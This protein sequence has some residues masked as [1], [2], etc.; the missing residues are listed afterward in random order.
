MLRRFLPF[1]VLIAGTLPAFAEKDWFGIYLQGKKLGYS[2]SNS[3]KDSTLGKEY[4]LRESA[5]IIQSEMMGS[6][7]QIDVI[8]QTWISPN[9]IIRSDYKSNSAGRVFNSRADFQDEKIA[10]VTSTGSSEEKITLNVPSNVRLIDDTMAISHE[11]LKDT[12]KTVVFDPTTVSLVEIKIL[13]DGK[14]KIESRGGQ[15]E[16]NKIIVDD[17]RAKMILFVSDKGELIRAEGPLGMTI[18]PEPENIAKDMTTGSDNVPD[19]AAASSIPVEGRIE[20]TAAITELEVTGVDLS[21]T[22]N[23]GHQIIEKYDDGWKVTISPIRKASMTTKIDVASKQQPNWIKPDSR[24]PSDKGIFRLR[25]QQMIGGETR[26]IPAAQKIRKEVYQR[27]RANL[28]IGVMRDATEIWDSSEG[29]C[30]DHAILMATLLRSVNIPTKLVTGLV[31]YQGSFLYHAW[32]E[33]WD[34]QQWVGLDSTRPDDY[35]TAGHLKTA[36]GTV[37]QAM[38]GFLLDGAKVKVVSPEVHFLKAG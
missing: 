3:K 35:L 7:L 32:V 2:W 36:E 38:V 4:D 24:I 29:V 33:V 10:V 1:L 16:A 15:V 28:G 30:R 9:G 27:M 17:P 12:R 20:F 26:V 25:A 5:T 31:Y 8:T 11:D 23:G 22:P 37:G 34:G 13:S 14:H 19:L 21:K 6:T 18:I